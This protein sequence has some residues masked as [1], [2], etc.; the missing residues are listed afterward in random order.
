MLGSELWVRDEGRP[1]DGERGGS[2]GGRNWREATRVR[3]MLAPQNGQ[4]NHLF[5]TAVVAQDP[6]AFLCG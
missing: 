1:G 3:A 2:G 6:G 4:D 5:G